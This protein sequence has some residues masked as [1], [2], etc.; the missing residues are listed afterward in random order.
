MKKIEAGSRIAILNVSNTR[1]F[2]QKESPDNRMLEF[3]HEPTHDDSH[4]AI[5]NI[6]L[7]EQIVPDLIADSIVDQHVIV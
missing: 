2:V 3:I 1:T 6:K 7:E 4:A 5:R